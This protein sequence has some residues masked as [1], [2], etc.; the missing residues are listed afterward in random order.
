MD[1]QQH[2]K[3]LNLPLHQNFVV[4]ILCKDLHAAGLSDKTAYQWKIQNGQAFIWTTAFDPDNYYRQAESIIDSHIITTIIPAYTSADMEKIVGNFYHTS[5]SGEHEVR[6][7][8][9][10][11]IGVRRAPRYPDALAMVAVE[12]LIRRII[13]PEAVNGIVQ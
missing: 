4:P 6:P 2:L 7:L 11:R 10:V 1:I 13:L 3:T 12:L 5:V 8:Q 9:F